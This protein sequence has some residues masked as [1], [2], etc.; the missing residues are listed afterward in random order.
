MRRS[1]PAL[2]LTLAT[3]IHLAAQ[4]PAPGG[5]SCASATWSGAR[6]LVVLY[7]GSAVACGVEP[8]ADGALWGW[9]GETWR[10]VAITG[11]PGP[12]EDG[13]LVALTPT[14]DLLLVGGRRDGMIHADT[15]R[16]DTTWHVVRT[17]ATT[18]GRLEHAAA[19]FDPNRREVVLFG[20]GLGSAPGQLSRQTGILKDSSWS[21]TTHAFGPAARVGH[22][23]TWSRQ[24]G[25]VLM[26]GGFATTGSFRD[27]WRWDGLRWHLVDSLGPTHTEGPALVGTDQGT[28]LFGAGLD[29]PPGQPLR[30]WRWRENDGWRPIA[31]SGGPP[32]RIG[33]QLV[34]DARRG[35]VVVLGGNLPGQGA[36]SEVWE[37]SANLNRWTRAQ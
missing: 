17:T 15:W 33:Q 4:A 1:F 13:H 7:G 5:R 24:H 18:P 10:R 2:L 9:N 6:Q 28:L 25:G 12:R 23:M 11:G 30:V 26:Y 32:L 34:Y 3:S 20:G 19:A 21:L 22:G 27:L 8:I 14:R 36:T 35:V 37:Y 31:S 16:Y 29:A